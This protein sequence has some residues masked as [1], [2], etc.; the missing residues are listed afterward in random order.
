MPRTA[1]VY[2]LALIH[3]DVVHASN[4]PSLSGVSGELSCHGGV[5]VVL[6]PKVQIQDDNPFLMK[7]HVRIINGYNSSS[8]ELLFDDLEEVAISG[9][10]DEEEGLLV[11]EGE[12]SQR[13]YE[14]ALGTVSYRSSAS[15][16][17]FSWYRSIAFSVHDGESSSPLIKGTMCSLVPEAAEGEAEAACMSVEEERA[18]AEQAAQA[19][20]MELKM[21]EQT[22]DEMKGKYSHTKS[23][24]SVIQSIEEESSSTV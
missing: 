13:D 9:V 15:T 4:V 10:W 20:E 12:A 6:A 21:T 18:A 11:L 23:A 17:S 14:K 24:F 8:D 2:L 19:A 7:A 3:A 5:A 16:L 22:R 1:A